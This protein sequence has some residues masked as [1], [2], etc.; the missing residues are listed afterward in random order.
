MLDKIIEKGVD[1]RDEPAAA[2]AAK[3]SIG[4]HRR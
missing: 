3:S 4:R 1:L 2:S